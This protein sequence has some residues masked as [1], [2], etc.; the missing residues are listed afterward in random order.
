MHLAHR[1]HARAALVPVLALLALGCSRQDGA[2]P[3]SS[4]HVDFSDAAVD[5]GVQGLDPSVQHLRESGI[6]GNIQRLDSLVPQ[7]LCRPPCRKDLYPH[8]SQTL[9]KGDNPRFIRN[10]NNRPLDP[11]HTLTPQIRISNI[12]IRNKFE[13]QMT[14]FLSKQI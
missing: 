3:D 14:E 9:C 10:A 8:L 4:I 12:E 1:P 7:C 13:I 5:A 6:I 2:A 11:A